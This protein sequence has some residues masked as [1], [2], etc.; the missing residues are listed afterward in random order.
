MWRFTQSR[1]VTRKEL[2]SVIKVGFSTVNSDCPTKLNDCQDRKKGCLDCQRKASEM[3][4]STDSHDTASLP[5]PPIKSITEENRKKVVPAIQT[6]VILESRQF[7]IHVTEHA[8]PIPRGL[9]TCC[10]NTSKRVQCQRSKYKYPHLC[11]R[12]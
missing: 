8:P 7:A 9:K 11:Y 5:A 1:C 2:A 10:H 12:G 4:P 6:H 3:L